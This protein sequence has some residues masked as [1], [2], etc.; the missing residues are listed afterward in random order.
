ME[1]EISES[2][3][4]IVVG[5]NKTGKGY[6]AWFCGRGLSETIYVGRTPLSAIKRLLEAGRHAL[7]K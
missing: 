3:I 7:V 6:Y 4:N 5:K 2:M 1:M